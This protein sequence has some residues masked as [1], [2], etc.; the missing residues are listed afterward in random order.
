[1]QKAAKSGVSVTFVC[2]NPCAT[3]FEA[4]TFDEAM[5]LEDLFGHFPTARSDVDLLREANRV[6]KPGG[7]LHLSS[8]D[9][10]WIRRSIRSD[11]IDGVPTGF[12]NRHSLLSNDGHA[13]QTVVTRSDGG[14]A[15]RRTMTEWLYTPREVT[16]LLHRLQFD[17]ITYD[18]ATGT[19]L[20]ARAPGK[21]PKYVIHCRSGRNIPP[22]QVVLQK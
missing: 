19:H 16:D 4:G 9:G 6:L 21:A 2:G 14:I 5:L 7:Q 11:A 15:R 17:S 1:M 20:R 3:L 10:G 22:L 13:L 18:D 12:I 8:S